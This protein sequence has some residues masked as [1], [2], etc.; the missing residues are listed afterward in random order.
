MREVHQNTH[1]LPE[2]NH[3]TILMHNKPPIQRCVRQSIKCTLPDF[4][5]PVLWSATAVLAPT[6][7]RPTFVEIPKMATA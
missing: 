3:I 7:G 4:F 5:S 1:N 6:H 2:G